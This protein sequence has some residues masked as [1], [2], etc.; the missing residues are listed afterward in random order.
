M[1]ADPTSVPG[2]PVWFMCAIGVQGWMTWD[3]AHNAFRARIEGRKVAPPTIYMKLIVGVVELAIFYFLPKSHHFTFN[4]GVGLGLS[5]AV[6]AAFYAGVFSQ[7]ADFLVRL[8]TDQDREQYFSELKPF[9]ALNFKFDFYFWV[10]R[11]V[12][13]VF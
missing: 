5:V 7:S 10:A 1:S 13:L 3:H 9:V 11:C 6:L 2:F 8:K 12:T 4:L